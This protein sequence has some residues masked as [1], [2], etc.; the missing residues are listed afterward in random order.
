MEFLRLS[1]EQTSVVRSTLKSLNSTLLAVS[2]NERTFSRGLEN[3]AKH[4]NEE[5]GERE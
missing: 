5:D 4:M 1:K 3:M 2:D